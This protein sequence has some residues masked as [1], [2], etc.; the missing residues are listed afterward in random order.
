MA[1]E[2]HDGSRAH[3]GQSQCPVPG[4]LQ[5]PL[6]GEVAAAQR[7]P[8]SHDRGALG[9][10]GLGPQVEGKSPWKYPEKCCPNRCPNCKCFLIFRPCLAA[11]VF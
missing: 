9:L 11:D 1:P 2:A 3:P 5:P 6:A 10:E 8:M 4:G 7:R